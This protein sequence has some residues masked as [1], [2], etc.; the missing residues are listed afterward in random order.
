MF[1]VYACQG[2]SWTT[3]WLEVYE[4]NGLY[5][6]PSYLTRFINMKLTVFVYILDCWTVIK[7]FWEVVEWMQAC[8]YNRDV[9]RGVLSLL[10]YDAI[11]LEGLSTR[12]VAAQLT[13]CWTAKGPAGGTPFNIQPVTTFLQSSCQLFLQHY[14]FLCPNCHLWLNVSCL[15]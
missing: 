9:E 3:V 15:G 14:I 4:D 10:E 2:I 1:L 6:A 12:P 8:G 11:P 7:C 13:F 5:I